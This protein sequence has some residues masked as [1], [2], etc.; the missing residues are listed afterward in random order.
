MLV[1]AYPEPVIIDVTPGDIVK[2][3][4][5]G[6]SYTRKQIDDLHL[7]GY[8]D[9]FE[10]GDNVLELR[11]C[12]FCESHMGVIREDVTCPYCGVKGLRIDERSMLT[13]CCGK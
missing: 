3:C 7:K 6:A 4:H 11:A 8:T 10:D 2:Y 12:D 9:L 5:C 13:T 1:I